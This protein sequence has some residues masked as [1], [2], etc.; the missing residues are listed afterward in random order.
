MEQYCLMLEELY[1][2]NK[3]FDSVSFRGHRM[4]RP[5]RRRLS[6][7]PPQPPQIKTSGGIIRYCT[8]YG[9]YKYALVQGV[10]SEKWSFPKGHI[11]EGEN[12]YECCMREVREETG[13]D[14]LPIP[15][16]SLQIGYGYYYVFEVE[17]EY[18][19]EAKDPVEIMCT[20]WVTIDE[21]R[22]MSLNADV[23]QYVRFLTN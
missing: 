13:L 23:S 2:Y 15:M 19:L 12:E 4:H 11:K 18:E 14:W 17:G 8:K 7:P 5:K 3:A 10:Y 21:M 6:Q 20:R 9:D 22:K 1:T 16:T